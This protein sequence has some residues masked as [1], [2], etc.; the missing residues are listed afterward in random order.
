LRSAC[1]P[2]GGLITP[3]NALGRVMADPGVPGLHLT[4]LEAGMTFHLI[5]AIR[6]G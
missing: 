1:L 2:D 3:P 4:V 5:P 6:Q